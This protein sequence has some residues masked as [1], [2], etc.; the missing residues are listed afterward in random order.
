M[1]FQLRQFLDL[2]RTWPGR[3]QGVRAPGPDG[4]DSG[5]APPWSGTTRAKRYKY[6]AVVKLL[7]KQDGDPE[8]ALPGP[9]CLAVVRAAHLETHHSKFFSALVTSGEGS[10]P[11]GNAP[12]AVT[13]V[14]VGD[15][16]GDYLTPGEHFALLRGGDVARGTV[17]RRIF[18]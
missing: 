9:V 18:V 10:G 17:T 7:P 2:M 8:A 6:E 16:A 13:M 5:K 11:P 14:V 12:I 1:Q 4:P 15:D 3:S